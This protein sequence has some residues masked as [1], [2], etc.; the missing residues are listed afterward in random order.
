MLMFQFVD[1]VTKLITCRMMDQGSLEA[2]DRRGL[3][4]LIACRRCP[5]DA[6]DKILL[7]RKEAMFILPHQ[8][9]HQKVH[10]SCLSKKAWFSRN[11]GHYAV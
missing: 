7:S 8:W 10:D 6:I 1:Q 2:D 9:W 11:G 3:A 5:S 4:S